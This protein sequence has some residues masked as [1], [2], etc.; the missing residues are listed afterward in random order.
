VP[1]EPLR[2]N[3]RGCIGREN[4]PVH[5]ALT[6]EQINLMLTNLPVDITFVDENDKVCFFSQTSERISCAPPRL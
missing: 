3:A 5:R 2:K 1:A 6:Q 4:Q